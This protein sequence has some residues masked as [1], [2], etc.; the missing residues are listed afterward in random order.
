M[1]T[2]PCQAT[3]WRVQTAHLRTSHR[4]WKVPLHTCKTMHLFEPSAWTLT[5]SRPGTASAPKAAQGRIEPQPSS[6][7]SFLNTSGRGP[8]L[9]DIRSRSS[10]VTMSCSAVTDQSCCACCRAGNRPARHPQALH[11]NPAAP[12]QEQLSHRPGH[13]RSP[14]LHHPLQRCTLLAS[15]KHPMPGALYAWPLPARLC[16]H[17]LQHLEQG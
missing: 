6:L 9:I 5:N 7:A 12:A 15:L 16:L 10:G 8:I 11:S 17:V 3:A 14:P 4:C 2:T 13:G 1:H